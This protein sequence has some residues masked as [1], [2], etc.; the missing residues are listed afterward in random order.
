MNEITNQEDS[1][2]LE[3]PTHRIAASSLPHHSSE[4][5]PLD[6]E[7]DFIDEFKSIKDE[8]LS[9]LSF[10]SKLYKPS[11][12]IGILFGLVGFFI[13]IIQLI[14]LSYL[15]QESIFFWNLCGFTTSVLVYYTGFSAFKFKNIERQRSYKVMMV[16]LGLIQLNALVNAFGYNSWWA[17]KN[18][19]IVIQFIALCY[20]I[21]VFIGSWTIK[22]DF[23]SNTKR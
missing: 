17:G 8:L 7:S 14:Q 13:S 12:L 10:L 15:D 3:G 23:K 20:T 4:N 16:V 19:N 1:H 11:L 2:S 21:L 18:F 22:I 9:N 6:Q 5:A